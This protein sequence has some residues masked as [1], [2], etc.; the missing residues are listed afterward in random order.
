MAHGPHKLR[1]RFLDGL[2]DLDWLFI[3]K[4]D[5]VVSLQANTGGF[6]SARSGGG[7]DVKT[8]APSAAIWEELTFDDLNGGSLVDGD[9]IDIQVLDGLYLT[10][11]AGQVVSADQ[12]AT[13]PATEFTI[14]VQ[15]GG[16]FG[17]GA[18]I[19]LESSDKAHYLTASPPNELDASGTSVGA[20]QTF[21]VGF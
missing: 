5:R 11:G 6:L 21:T 9:V 15:G 1:L 20:A 12:R 13:S 17:D 2:V 19:A 3:E 14:V 7:L 8:D 16:T 18:K 10:V 4:L